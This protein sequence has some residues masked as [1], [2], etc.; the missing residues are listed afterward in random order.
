MGG[1]PTAAANVSV[2]M[3][4]TPSPTRRS[5]LPAVFPTALA[6]VFVAAALVLSACSDEPDEIIAVSD[7]SGEDTPAETTEDDTMDDQPVTDPATDGRWERTRTR[8]D[9][10]QTQPATP[11]EVVVDPDDDAVVL[12]RYEGAAE[13][14]S[15]VD[16]ELI[17]SDDA[18]EVQLISGLDP[19]VAAMS[20]IAGVF[21]YEVAVPLSAPLGDRSL[22][23]AAAAN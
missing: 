22:R 7:P 9:L 18:V 23:I 2:G 3:N 21:D 4:P 6:A 15:G 10:I 12:V 20:C 16:V 13:P 19:D 8:S 5:P 14:C 17:E 11:I 1:N